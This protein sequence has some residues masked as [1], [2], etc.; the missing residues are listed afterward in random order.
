MC[1]PGK[2]I[3]NHLKRNIHKEYTTVSRSSEIWLSDTRRKGF[4]IKR[5]IYNG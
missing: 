4:S 1:D 3:I 5:L 2:A